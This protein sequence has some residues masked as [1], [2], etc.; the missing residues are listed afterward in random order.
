M[1][2]AEPRSTEGLAS[3]KGCSYFDFRTIPE[4]LEPG[5]E[6]WG[7]YEYKRGFGG[8]SRLNLPTQ[9]YVYRPVVYTAWRML[10][11]LKRQRRATERRKIELDRAARG[12]KD[13]G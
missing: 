13:E 4:V 1:K 5:Q 6:M 9:D 11:D 7:V 12:N 10:V 3:V 8:F 2:M